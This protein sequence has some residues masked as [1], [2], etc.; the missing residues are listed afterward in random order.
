MK[1]KFL[2]FLL[3]ITLNS[4]CQKKTKP[5]SWKYSTYDIFYGQ[6]VFLSNHFYQQLNSI[7]NFN[8]NQPLK[9][10]GVGCNLVTDFA[11]SEYSDGS[12]LQ[13]NV[14]Y[15][16]VIPQ[17]III[18]D[19]IKSKITGGLFG[20]GIFTYE[21]FLN[22]KS[23]DVLF[24]I[25]FNAGRLKIYDN[26]CLNAINPYFAPKLIIQPRLKLGKIV[27]SLRFEYEY[28]VTNSDWKTYKGV[29]I[30]ELQSINQTG[31]TC[32]FGLGYAIN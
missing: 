23:A 27:A 9:L 12:E 4:F 8:V 19:S 10:A 1:F 31:I 28:D 25:G 6:K 20:M 32:F 21:V 2:A 18:R 26:T 3:L 29:I 13:F 16:Q 14:T 5:F 15:S 24:T 22:K 30:P 11:G 7:D 17:D